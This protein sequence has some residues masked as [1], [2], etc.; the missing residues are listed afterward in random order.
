MPYF[1]ETAPAYG[2]PLAV[3]RGAPLAENPAVAAILALMDIA[4]NGFQR[5]SV[6]DS[7]RNP[8]LACPDLTDV[9]IAQLDVI[10]RSRI[11]V[12]GRHNWL[13]AVE[14]AGHVVADPDDPHHESPANQVSTEEAAAL[15][16]A[17]DQFFTRITPLEEATAREY[18]RWLEA[19]IGAD[20][21]AYEE[22]A[23][24]DK[25]IPASG[26]EVL[27]RIREG[28]EPAL[29]ARDLLALDCVKRVF[30]E[31]LS[32]YDL[33]DSYTPVSWEVFRLD[34]QIAIDHS[35]VNTARTANRLGRV[36]LASVFEARGLPHD[37]VFLVGL[38]EGEFPAR[39]P[40]SAL[41]T[42]EERHRFQGQGIAL[43]S[44]A[45]QADEGS[46]FYEM[47]ALA[48]RSLTLSRPYIDG[49]GNEWP[50]RSFKMLP[51]RRK[52]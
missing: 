37:H 4:A 14:V 20:P 31:V 17:L 35:T 12:R 29:V 40:E 18:I 51:A 22:P 41:Y 42:D 1:L 46:L 49:R 32:A 21:Q 25:S 15:Y 10:S 38:S 16:T 28:L 19:L 27:A 13:E 6:I 45:E 39:A 52:C 43:S 50:K 7:L 47:T 44:R 9:Q 30:R 11:V 26:F 8:Y 3:K 48:H 23:D 34:L 24:V 2:I 36:L 33:V 5:R